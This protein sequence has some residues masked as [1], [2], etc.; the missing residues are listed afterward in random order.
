MGEGLIVKGFCKSWKLSLKVLALCIAL[1]EYGDLSIIHE[2]YWHG[3]RNNEA[4][5]DQ[6]AI[7][8]LVK[9]N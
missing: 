5:N 1:L 8:C 4:E 6:A 9:R 3:S 7:D 2:L